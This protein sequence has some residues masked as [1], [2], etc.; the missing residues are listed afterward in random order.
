MNCLN[1]NRQF[2][3]MLYLYAFLTIVVRETDHGREAGLGRGRQKEK[4]MAKVKEKALVL[5]NLEVSMPCPAVVAPECH[6]C[7][8]LH[9]VYS[10]M[11][12]DTKDP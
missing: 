10:V 3:Y 5:G 4:L 11:T 2:P 6:P 12:V 8:L 7:H 9:Y 1:V